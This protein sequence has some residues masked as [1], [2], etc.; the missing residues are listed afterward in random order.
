MSIIRYQV[1]IWIIWIWIASLCTVCHSEFTVS[2]VPLEY[3]YLDKKIMEYVFIV[4]YQHHEDLYVDLRTTDNYYPG[5]SGYVQCCRNTT[6]N[7][8]STANCIDYEWQSISLPVDPE[9][10]FVNYTF[11]TPYLGSNYFVELEVIQ[12]EVQL[13]SGTTRNYYYDEYLYAGIKKSFF[14]RVGNRLFYGE[15]LDVLGFHETE[16]IFKIRI[17]GPGQFIQPVKNFHNFISYS[18]ISDVENYNFPPFICEPRRGYQEFTSRSLL[19]PFICEDK[20]PPTENPIQDYSNRYTRL[21]TEN[22][23]NRFVFSIVANMIDYRTGDSYDHFN[24]N[25]ND[26]I[27]F[28]FLNL[29]NKSGHPIFHPDNYTVTA[30]M[31]Y[32]PCDPELL[33][34]ENPILK[35]NFTEIPP[36]LLH[37][38]KEQFSLLVNYIY[39]FFLKIKIDTILG[40]VF[41]DNFI[42]CRIDIDS[43]LMKYTAREYPT[44]WISG[45]PYPSSDEKYSSDPCCNKSLTQTK[46]CTPVP[47]TRHMFSLVKDTTAIEQECTQSACTNK[48]LSIYERL[49]TEYKTSRRLIDLLELNLDEMLSKCE[50]QLFENDCRYDSHCQKKLGMKSFC[51]D[52]PDVSITAF[53][54]RK[55]CTVPCEHDSDCVLS[56]KCDSYGRHKFCRKP[57]F[58][59]TQNMTRVHAHLTQCVINQLKWMNEEYIT[60]LFS[61]YNVNA[62]KL[63]DLSVIADDLSGDMTCINGSSQYDTLLCDDRQACNW[64]SERY[65]YPDSLNCNIRGQFCAV[66]TYYST[67]QYQEVSQNGDCILYSYA[68]LGYYPRIVDNVVLSN[69]PYVQSYIGSTH[70]RISG[71]TQDE[72]FYDNIICTPNNVQPVKTLLLNTGYQGYP[73]GTEGYFCSPVCYS[74]TLNETECIQSGYQFSYEYK[75]PLCIVPTLQHDY[76]Y[77]DRYACQREDFIHWPGGIYLEPTKNNETT[78][79]PYCRYNDS[80]TKEECIYHD[81]YHCTNPFCNNCSKEE[82][83]AS[84]YCDMAEGCY[85]PYD[86]SSQCQFSIREEIPL[87]WKRYSDMRHQG[88][89]K[90]TPYGCLMKSIPGLFINQITCERVFQGTYL[91]RE[92]LLQLDQEECRNIYSSCQK[93]PSR[94]QSLRPDTEDLFD[95]LECEKCDYGWISPNWIPGRWELYDE[96]EWVEP[97]WR[98]R[99]YTNTYEEYMGISLSKF[100]GTFFYFRYKLLLRYLTDVSFEFRDLVDS[101]SRSLCYCTGKECDSCFEETESELNF[102]SIFYVCS[103]S[104]YN[105]TSDFAALFIPE[106]H[107]EE[108]SCIDIDHLSTTILSTENYPSPRHFYTQW[109]RDSFSFVNTHR[110]VFG[111]VIQNGFGYFMNLT[112]STE[113]VFA[114]ATLCIFPPTVLPT[115]NYSSYK[116]VVTEIVSPSNIQNAPSYDF[117]PGEILCIPF[118]PNVY[119]IPIGFQDSLENST[120]LDTFEEAEIVVLSLALIYYVIL[121]IINIIFI[122]SKVY[123][124][125]IC[126]SSTFSHDLSFPVLFLMVA[127]V[128]ITNVVVIQNDLEEGFISYSVFYIEITYVLYMIANSIFI[129]RWVYQNKLHTKDKNSGMCSSVFILSQSPFVAVGSGIILS[130]YWIIYAITA[131][132]E[133]V[134]LATINVFSYGFFWI[135]VILFISVVLT[136]I[137]TCGE[138]CRCDMISWNYRA[139]LASL[140]GLLGQIIFMLHTVDWN[141][142]WYWRIESHFSYLMIIDGSF[143]VFYLLIT[144]PFVCNCKKTYK[145]Q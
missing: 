19:A 62:T 138:C 48:Y 134:E 38:S 114:N 81:E 5:P 144:S 33:D 13:F 36:N 105:L 113:K 122:F 127:I 61:F 99:A 64:F 46:C 41:S 34:T 97:T 116:Y 47:G 29:V 4:D 88:A 20:Y 50:Q 137:M 22:K 121:V 84:G 26:K 118:I 42:G 104:E 94:Y 89:F 82:C 77:L 124:K 59:F 68:Q 95:K 109:N 93:S 85:I 6:T 107:I 24:P 139:L 51:I 112:R 108:T 23:E 58:K 106:T 101:V 119:F 92:Y 69:T 135:Y 130:S 71:K 65:L 1:I 75:V 9:V 49:H 111:S 110:V 128:R 10:G 52:D 102:E 18:L 141:D 12:G 115:K 87:S 3:N 91:S 83:E 129:T 56:Y 7:C 37:K 103:G 123:A 17:L 140:L 70:F 143:T 100:K 96:R 73:E 131:L 55:I 35:K 136:V 63:T 45:C 90:W 76:A 120:Y 72:C 44:W 32:Y 67:K 21:A 27:Q 15:L 126:I 31:K 117:V 30:T 60:E 8:R 54:T 133:D 16:V 28:Q 98:T 25:F 132:S 14:Y 57:L 2:Y 142:G 78:C 11:T 43:R 80:K 74:L 125:N 40:S 39:D 53:G 145:I 86:S 79:V 66:D